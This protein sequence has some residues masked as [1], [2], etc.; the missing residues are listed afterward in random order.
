VGVYFCQFLIKS[1]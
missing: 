1:N